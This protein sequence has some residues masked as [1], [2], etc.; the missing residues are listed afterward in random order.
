M[1]MCGCGQPSLVACACK[2]F[3]KCANHYDSS[4]MTSSAHPFHQ[5][6]LIFEGSVSIQNYFK[7]Q[8][9]TRNFLAILSIYNK[10]YPLS[11]SNWIIQSLSTSTTLPSSCVQSILE[12]EI[13]ELSPL[14]SKFSS[15]EDLTGYSQDLSLLKSHLSEFI[16][17]S[18]PRNFDKLEMWIELCSL[19][20]KGLVSKVSC[21]L[22][23][24][25]HDCLFN[26]KT[27][28]FIND[29]LTATFP[30]D[31]V[32]MNMFKEFY[33]MKAIKS[34]PEI[35]SIVINSINS[36]HVWKY[37]YQLVKILIALSQ[38]ESIIV[39]GEKNLGEFA[40][41][42]NI[43]NS[44]LL[45]IIEAVEKLEPGSPFC[46]LISKNLKAFKFEIELNKQGDALKGYLKFFS[47]TDSTRK[48]NWLIASSRAQYYLDK[49]AVLLNL[50]M[51]QIN[52]DQQ[53]IIKVSI[54]ALSETALH[55]YD[56]YLLKMLRQFE[57]NNTLKLV[58]YC[59]K[60]PYNWKI[61]LQDLR[62]QLPLSVFPMNQEVSNSER[63]NVF[64]IKI[65]N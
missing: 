36:T 31:S 38:L 11:S 3:S 24:K 35:V 65:I 12:R 44:Y 41:I 25:S 30:S 2:Q 28:G 21:E 14:G 6:E 40:G 29:N 43:K 39:N 47:R 53:K 20:N 54:K 26:T 56:L 1:N 33:F 32:P 5:V 61:N 9:K 49:L 16:P 62:I 59:R 51:N 8:S 58:E 37:S 7:S 63:Y 4:Q 27:F 13:E 52:S 57:A 18:K 50:K 23:G 15:I 10:F 48:I 19:G 64:I 46:D 22:N 42:P 34:N 60:L 45:A 55:T 17:E